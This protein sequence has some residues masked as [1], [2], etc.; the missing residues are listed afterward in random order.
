MHKKR[1]KF[2]IKSKSKRKKELQKLRI[3]YISAKTEEER[4]DIYLK[5]LKMNPNLTLEEFLSPLKKQK[6][7][8]N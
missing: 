8:G 5:V 1:R 4:R 2:S 3:K 7:D 6:Q